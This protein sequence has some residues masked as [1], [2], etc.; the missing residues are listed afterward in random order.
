MFATF[1]TLIFFQVSS[2]P[3][4]SSLVARTETSIS[5]KRAKY[6]DI[7]ARFYVMK[8]QHFLAGHVLYKLAECHS[9]DGIGITLEQRYVIMFL[10]ISKSK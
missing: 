5:I 10:E 6:L 7:L 4:M 2:I 9:S 3:S 8:R 1:F